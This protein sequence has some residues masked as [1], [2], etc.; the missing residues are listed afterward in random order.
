M[1]SG[2]QF[3]MK[4][5]LDIQWHDDVRKGKFLFF[6][7]NFF[8]ISSFLYGFEAFNFSFHILL[9][10]DKKAKKCLRELAWQL[11]LNFWCLYIQQIFK[12]SSKFHF[13]WYSN[14]VQ[15]LS[16]V[17]SCVGDEN[18][19]GRFECLVKIFGLIKH[20]MKDMKKRITSSF[21]LFLVFRNG[22]VVQFDI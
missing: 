19:H 22:K 2:E 3:L 12:E 7:C 17:W 10:N 16:C 18:C 14:L 8:S 11:E 6:S 4:I 13:D 9:Y 15:H 1:R 21:Y 5:I 20:M